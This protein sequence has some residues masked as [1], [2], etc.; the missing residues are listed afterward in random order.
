MG[1]RADGNFDDEHAL[2]VVRQRNHVA[3]GHL[4]PQLGR[5]G[6]HGDANVPLGLGLVLAGPAFGLF[7]ILSEKFL[8]V[9]DWNCERYPS[10]YFHRIDSNHFTVQVHQW[11]TGVSK[12]K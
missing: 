6:D 4:V 1:W 8:R 12:L 9:I 2:D 5:N 7:D 10:C 11:T 3:L